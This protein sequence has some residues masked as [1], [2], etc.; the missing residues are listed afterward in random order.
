MNNSEQ[1]VLQNHLARFIIDEVFN[2]PEEKDLLHIKTPTK[3]VYRDMELNQ[4]QI[5]QLRGE[6]ERLLNSELWKIISNALKQDAI[7]RGVYK[8]VTEADMIASKAELY[9]LQTIENLLKHMSQP[10]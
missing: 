6:A 3:W 9:F 2:L 10:G 4:A 1:T 7:N 5:I 8:S